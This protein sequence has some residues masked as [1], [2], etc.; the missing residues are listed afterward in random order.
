LGVKEIK[1]A[2]I[3]V[4]GM[5]MENYTLTFNKVNAGYQKRPVLK[6]ISIQFEMG[7]VSAL[8]GPNGAG[9]STLIKAASGIL[10]VTSGIVKINGYDIFRLKPAE[11]ARLVSV[12]PQARNLPP[13]FTVREVVMMGRTA[14][15]GWFGQFTNADFE[16]V[17]QALERTDTVS[18]AARR[19]GEISG[20]EAQ[21]VLLARAIAQQARVMLLDEPTTHLDIL[22]QVNLLDLIR[23]LTHEDNLV[24]VLAIHDLNLVSRYADHVALMV[25]GRI[26]DKGMPEQVLTP[27][28]LSRGYNLGMNV[29][30]PIDSTHPV[31]LPSE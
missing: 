10:P 29:I 1:T 9:K 15:T 12:I 14:Y 6:E 3:L 30:R 5:E 4:I 17:D 16:I 22:Y 2:G 31:I 19:M 25:E 28:K 23:K 27:D 21:R 13:A 26:Q 18:L 8:I 24:V 20:G 7:K 11:R